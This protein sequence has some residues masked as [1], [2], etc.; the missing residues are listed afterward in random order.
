MAHPGEHEW[1]E[2][3]RASLAG[4]AA[5]Y[6]RLLAAL[7][8][9]VRSSVRRGLARSGAPAAETEDIVQE[10]L[11]AIHVRRAS[12]DPALP[13]APWVAAIT[14]YKLVDVLRR[15]GRRAEVPIEP[16]AGALAA[17]A[18]E[19]ASGRD[20]ARALATLPPRQRS[21]LEGLAV[22]GETIGEAAR[23]L[24][25]SEGAVRVA[26][27]RGLAALAARFGQEDVGKQNVGKED[28]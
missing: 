13:L 1:D 17:P 12:W 19:R 5:A 16:L 11:L 23:R 24:S 15:R 9:A 25:I 8:P 3:M 22:A 2:L 6:R 26:L 14:R 18:E 28:G 21:V 7:A 27:H 10:V 4:D 20:V